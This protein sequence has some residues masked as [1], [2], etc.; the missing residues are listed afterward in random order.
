M[1]LTK[2]ASLNNFMVQ[3]SSN[4]N[5]NTAVSVFFY[6]TK[7][8][9]SSNSGGEAQGGRGHDISVLVRVYLYKIFR[10]GRCIENNGKRGE[11]I[12]P[13]K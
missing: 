11:P 2:S 10:T 13:G 9:E 1:S 8:K 7:N 12:E 4:L 6:N 5:S 3:S